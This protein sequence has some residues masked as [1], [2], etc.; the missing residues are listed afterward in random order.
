MYVHAQL[1]STLK[2]VLLIYYAVFKHL[3]LLTKSTAD[4]SKICIGVKANVA[5]N[6]DF[7]FKEYNT[8]G[9]MLIQEMMIWCWTTW[10]KSSNVGVKVQDLRLFELLRMLV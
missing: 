6:F 3:E 4:V 2:I 7:L 5:L 9:P 8:L 10:I 1:K